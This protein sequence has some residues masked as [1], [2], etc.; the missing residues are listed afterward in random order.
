L[1]SRFEDRLDIG[2]IVLNQLKC[3]LVIN[4]EMVGACRLSQTEKYFSSK[5]LVN[6]SDTLVL[7]T[8][9]EM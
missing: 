5:D 8:L 9:Y 2:I 1:L 4:E 7:Q 6:A 3:K